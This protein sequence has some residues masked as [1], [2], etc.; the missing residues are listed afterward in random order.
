MKVNF[1]ARTIEMSAKEMRKA[2]VPYSREFSDLLQ[3]QRD[4]P[5]FTIVINRPC[6]PTNNP[7][8]GL[9]YEY[10]KQHISQ[11]A[12]ERLDEFDN[13]R[14]IFGYSRTAQWFRNVFSEAC[15]TAHFCTSDELTA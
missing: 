8:R 15:A 14:K 12:P 5:N 7:N 2:S 13:V 4:L 9:T 3:L 1:V 6:I 11:N 10:M